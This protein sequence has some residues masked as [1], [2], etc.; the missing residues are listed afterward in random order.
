MNTKDFVKKSVAFSLGAAAF[1]AEKLK[2]FSEEM[3]S[4]G[5]ITS[6]EAKHFVDDVS[7]KAD[8]EKQS[9]QEWWQEQVGKML[10]QAGA[11]DAARFVQLEQRVALL[12]MRLT[13]LAEEAAAAEELAG[14]ACPD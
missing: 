14:P 6:D 7:K 1:S 2:A 12:E 9:I 5:E 4:K 13:E 8:E 3:V 11:V 10:Q